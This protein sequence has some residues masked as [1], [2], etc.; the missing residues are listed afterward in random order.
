M[1]HMHS[2]NLERPLLMRAPRSCP[3]NTLDVYAIPEPPLRRPICHVH[4]HASLSSYYPTPFRGRGRPATLQPP[5]RPKHVTSPL[6]SQPASTHTSQKD[7]RESDTQFKK[8]GARERES[9]REREKG[10]EREKKREEQG[11]FPPSAV[12]SASGS[13]PVPLRRTRLGVV[14]VDG[15]AVGVIVLHPSRR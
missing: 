3:L 5:H 14:I 7:R 13:R 1:R 2:K 6:T 12:P 11:H 10:R 8:A 15:A 4:V 9:E